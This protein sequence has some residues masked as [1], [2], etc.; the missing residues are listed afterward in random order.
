M[1][2][3]DYIGFGIIL[4][5]LL[6]SNS[7]EPFHTLFSL[8]NPA[9]QYPHAEHERVPTPMLYVY[10]IAIPFA[11]IA[12][13][14]LLTRSSAHK[15]HVSLLGLGITL[16]LAELLT[17]IIKNAVGRP[18][19]DLLSRCKPKAGTPT[20]GLVGI[21]VC[22]ET[23][24]HT[25][26]DG[27][28]SFPSGHSS[29]SF[30]GLG[31]LALHLAGQLRALHTGADLP[32]FLICL[33]PLLAAGGVAVSRLEDYRHDPYDVT[34]GSLLGFTVAYFS[35]R[36]YFPRLR[37]ANCAEPYA[38]SVDGSRLKGRDEEMGNGGVRDAGEFELAPTD[39]SDGEDEG[40][41]LHANENGA[42]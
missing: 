22:T 8:D 25:L 17:N 26:Q 1:Y 5:A 27:W 4:A 40:L 42:R 12:A 29:F 9:I 11:S 13:Y 37:S 23:D 36:R 15:L 24:P 2:A 20:T 18:R 19:P 38:V 14:L 34:V 30:A 35:Y 41:P 16:V 7:F 28:R 6:V 31:Y 21:D 32:R 33:I 39:E 10:A 3:L